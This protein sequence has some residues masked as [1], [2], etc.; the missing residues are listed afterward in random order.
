M[1]IQMR[2]LE[3]VILKF[4]RLPAI[5]EEEIE[6]AVSIAARDIRERAQDEHN[7]ISRTGDTEKYGVDSNVTGLIGVVELATPNAIG[8]HEGRPAHIIKPRNKMA[9]RFPLGGMLVFASRVRHPGNKPDPYLF[10]AAD[11]ETPAIM[12]R[13]DAVIARALQD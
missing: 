10:D 3:D 1:I 13:F 12:A 11:K 6:I 9:L 5:I 4:G 8:L 7:W 2:G